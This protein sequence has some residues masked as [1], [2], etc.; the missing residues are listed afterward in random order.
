METIL[1][2]A[3]PMR[4][5]GQVDLIHDH[6]SLP[7]KDFFRLLTALLGGLSQAPVSVS[8]AI[9][10]MCYA[11]TAFVGNSTEQLNL[12]TDLELLKSEID[13]ANL[14]SLPHF[15]PRRKRAKWIKWQLFEYVRLLVKSQTNPD[16]KY[17]GIYLFCLLKGVKHN[18]R[19]PT[20]LFKF[21]KSGVGRLTERELRTLLQMEL[22]A[23][24]YL[25]DAEEG[26]SESFEEKVSFHYQNKIYF[27]DSK[28]RQSVYD[29]KT[30][31]SA[32]FESLCRQLKSMSKDVELSKSACLTLIAMI[33]NLPIG[34]I[35]DIPILEHTTDEWVI[36]LSITDWVIY[37]DLSIIAPGAANLVG[38]QFIP[39]SQVLVKPL[40]L[41]LAKVLQEHLSKAPEAIKTIGDFIGSDVRLPDIRPSKLV[42]TYAKYASDKVDIFMGGLLANDFRGFPKSR[43]YYAQITRLEIWE[44]SKKVFDSL[45]F[46]ET[47]TVVTGLNIGSSAVLADQAITKLFSELANSVEEARTSNNAPLERVIF[48]HEKYTAY[49]AT[50][51][52]FCFALRDANPIDVQSNQV[53]QGQKFLIVNDKEVHDDA[54]PQPVTICQILH[55]QFELYRAH[56]VAL[57]MRL[58]KAKNP[59]FNKFKQSLES[60]LAGDARSIFITPTALKGFSS[61]KVSSAWSIQVPLNFGR[62]YWASNFRRLGISDREISAHLRHQ[63]KGNLNWSTDSNLILSSFIQRVDEAQTQ[64]LLELDI[65]AISGLIRSAA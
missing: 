33:T 10:G 56:C 46:G 27:A 48:F 54:T 44:A 26:F 35:Q 24:L 12:L 16:L 5:F 36:A 18:K 14:V 60:V 21:L 62:H 40:P 50:L 39:A 49:V 8:A 22:N 31:S 57:L 61:T 64:K 20:M 52:I 17:V 37:F 19:I 42:N 13:N 7:R 43:V 15:N 55:E 2:M 51:A 38:E 3:N 4:Y 34:Y 65:H 9:E 23:K 29:R 28:T 63:Q 47:V 32:E 45:G 30:Y 25:S 58:N 53:L 59:T 1:G 6:L 11:L 41:F